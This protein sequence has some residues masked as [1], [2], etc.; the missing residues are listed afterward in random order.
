[1]TPAGRGP[2]NDHVPTDL[3]ALLV[4]E[5]SVSTEDLERATARQREAGGALDT[6]LL[7]LELLPESVLAA[8]LSRASGLPPAPPTAWEAGDP[9]ARRVFPSRVAERHGLA[10]FALEGRELA[11]V[12]TNPVD[13]GLL[14]EI[15]FMLS[16][17]LTA[18][19]GPEWRVRTLI[20]RLYGGPLEPRFAALA[21]RA[22]DPVEAAPP[23]APAAAP[24]SAEPEQSFAL[25]E[26][27]ADE[28]ETS[29]ADAPAPRARAGGFARD[30]SEPLEPLAAA[31][32][33]ALES[34]DLAGLFEDEPPEPAAPAGA[35]ARGEPG[36][37]ADGGPEEAEAEPVAP[38]D[39]TAP[40]RWSLDDA[41][42]ALAAA[43]DRDAVVVAALR[44]A[45][46]FFELAAMF[47]VTRD[48]V[49]GHDALGRDPDARELC[50]GV[51]I[52][53]TDPGICR[54]V[55]ETCAPHLGPIPREAPGN[56]AIL[57][58]LG[59][60][61]PRTALVYPVLLRNRPVCLLY[62]DNGEAPVSPRRLGDLLLVL[63]I[64]GAAFERI[65]RDRKRRRRKRIAEAPPAPAAE[66]TPPEAPAADA[67]WSAVEPAAVPPAAPPP[68]T[69]E[70]APLDE[71][72]FVA[73]PALAPAPLARP[74]VAPEP[75]SEEDIDLDVDASPAETTDPEQPL[76][77]R[78]ARGERQDASARG[79]PVEPRAADPA[80][81]APDAPAPE[82]LAPPVPQD[83]AGWVD[84]LARSA[85]GSPERRE[86]L[87]RLLTDPVEALRALCAALP[88]PPD[89][90]AQDAL[91]AL[92]PI[93][94]AVAAFGS[95]AVPPLLA[96]AQEPDPVRRRAAVVILAAAGDPAAYPAL[97]DRAL[98]PDPDVSAAAADGLGAHRR[99]PGM[100]AIPEK[101]R[102]ALLSGLSSRASGAA[103]A[104]GA[105][106]DVD[107]I[108][109]LV[110]VLDTPDRATADA[111]GAALARITLQRHGSDPRAWL[112]W[113]KQ[114]RGR[115]RAEW[116]FSGLT[117]PEREV[118]VAAAAELAD[119]A[120]P[121]V[122][123]SPDA[124]PDEREN[125]ARSWAGW[126]SR[127]G[128]VL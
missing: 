117:N 2:T 81:G 103:R 40:P 47:A 29:F 6:A 49:A 57:D 74:Q 64:V 121:P 69:A 68:A 62:A 105:L 79:E 16:L 80:P 33:Q 28:D 95:R 116:L 15:S 126:W 75:L 123:Y 125:V 9:R 90:E 124:D 93:A 10:P 112:A 56:A 92:G 54:T 48:A 102:R 17:H 52:Y 114:N 46:D 82:S 60:E 61:T 24:A 58:G 97:A 122:T 85:P 27:P 113:W 45:R 3:A 12:A 84:A 91:G 4:E 38:P 44:Y 21:A 89:P 59:R 128:H 76:A 88:G 18:H 30:A 100:R 111:A 39:R 67:G 1:L 50:R 101:L 53:A 37:G 115:G 70:A 110:Q 19:V 11:L 98:D 63:S 42:A 35:A 51:A 73:D 118:R 94:A 5:G 65:L 26:Q 109:L 31:L 83:A 96:M 77:V 34:D 66:A 87:R 108:P 14:D 8:A 23:D 13:L 20:H 25:A 120:P 41:R 36:A 127:S 72:W 32:A 7:E 43:R 86:S 107:A 99:D 22:G 104:L 119:A 78:Q 55:I 71:S 106:R